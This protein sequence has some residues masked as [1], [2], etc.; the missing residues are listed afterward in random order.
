MS[1]T[2]EMIETFT[3]AMIYLNRENPDFSYAS[4]A[5]HFSWCLHLD[6]SACDAWRGIGYCENDGRGSV[7]EE[8]I[9][10]AWNA[11]DSFGRLLG[12]INCGEGS[13]DGM[14]ATG[15]WGTYRKWCTRADLTHAYATVLI[16]N[17][18]YDAAL[19]VLRSI[20]GDLPFTRLLLTRL[21]YVTRRWND[22]VSTGGSLDN[23]PEYLL[24]AD[25]PVVPLTVDHM[26][27]GLSALMVGE[28]LCYLEQFD[29]A[30]DRLDA[31][32]N[33][34][35]T[36][37]AARAAYLT[38]MA[39]RGRGDEKR[40]QDY[41]ARA[42]SRGDDPQVFA[43]KN[44]TS[45]KL[46]RTSAEMIAAR[47]SFWD[48]TTEP[49][50]DAHRADEHEQRRASLL[51]DAERKMDTLI[52][53]EAV[54]DQI[55]RL[56]Y[57][58]E[59]AMNRKRLGLPVKAT[60]QHIAFTGP[61]GC[62]QGDAL[63]AVNRA[64]KGFTMKLR[65][66]VERFNGNAPRKDWAWNP[67]IDTYVQREV[68]GVVRLVKLR[69]AWNSG[70]KTTYTVTTDTGR[71][72]RATDEHPFLTERG[73]LRLDQLIVG[74]K[75]HTATGSPDVDDEP[76]TIETVVSVELYGQEDTFDLEV[77]DDP[78]NFL[79][80]GFVVHNTGKTTV[81]G[82]VG[83]I[84]A[85]LGLI[86]NPKVTVVS[87]PD[88][89]GDKVGETA[90]KT[91]KV[92]DAADGGVLFIDEAY[93]LVPKDA[94]QVDFGQEVIE[95]LVTE[96]DLRRTTLIVIIAGYPGDIDRL[97]DANDGLRSRFYRKIEFASYDPSEIRA[98][99]EMMSKDMGFTLDSDAADYIER[100]TAT[101][102]MGRDSKGEKKLLDQVGNGRFVRNVVESA[103]EEQDV[104]NGRAASAK[105][106]GIETFDA[107]DVT[108]LTLS[109]VKTAVDRITDEYLHAR[110]APSDGF[111][112][113]VVDN[114]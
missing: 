17:R 102:L 109:D 95:V 105:G 9:V 15:M 110:P 19:R 30:A 36:V 90:L 16:E 104:R 106:V 87:R 4:A 35:N 74:D 28:A 21:Y 55:E 42:L 66:V 69:S 59:G 88:L 86:K 33:S 73:W 76:I 32:V 107:S 24:R 47:T 67:D 114:Y 82:I 13:L 12:D 72:L 81:A 53:L 8:Q 100:I 54:R 97:L 45:F 65:D 34:G 96:M 25:E 83:D 31:A 22:V 68:D 10:G 14:F 85:G 94:S 80:N 113:Q 89:V 99:A 2:P 38:G 6:N 70:V 71:T 58:V 101:V 27:H 91:R 98:I 111:V 64:G 37:V 92:I 29:S 50:L 52:G 84:Y 60:S 3:S 103:I 43:A 18:E 57:S 40:A 48:H 44:D 49:D 79:A 108:R 46:P 63:I 20:P 23:A 11:L 78:H 56:R 7:T 26:V 51:A 62:I 39:H 61:P 75:V 93:A 41:L 77:D 5:S 112:P 1:H